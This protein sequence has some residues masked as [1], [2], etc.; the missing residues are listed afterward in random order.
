[1][2]RALLQW[3]ADVES[4]SGGR[5]K[6]NVLTGACPDPEIYD[7]VARGAGDMGFNPIQFTT[8][9]FPS[10]EAMTLPDVGIKCMHPGQAA[11]ELWKTYPGVAE[12][13][14]DV[15]VLAI[16]AMTISPPGVSFVTSDKPVRK[17]EDFQGLKIGKYGEWGTKQ[18]AAMGCTPIAVPPH[19]IYEAMQRKIVDGSCLDPEMLESQMLCEVSGYLHCLCHEFS[20]VFFAMNKDVW[21]TIPS[22]VQKIMNDY[23]AGLPATIEADLTETMTRAIDMSVNEYGVEVIDYSEEELTRWRERQQPVQDEYI[24]MLEQKGIDGNKL[25]TEIKKLEDKYAE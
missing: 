8:G 19:E 7:V 5:I 17:L 21:S 25:F 14:S 11:W 16:W 6:I 18:L 1:M 2:G 13:F 9:R 4:A 24:A 10:L 3:N 23:A 20:P 12:E 15:Q 22:D